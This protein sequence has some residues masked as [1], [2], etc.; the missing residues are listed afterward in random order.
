[1]NLADMTGYAGLAGALI[2]GIA[3]IPQ[4][5]HLIHEKC[6]AGLSVR[7]FSL[8]L[9]ATLLITAHAIAIMD[10]VFIVL[11]LVQTAAIATILFY[12]KLYDGQVCPSHVTVA[13]VTKRSK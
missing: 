7:A 3:Y 10:P 1:M 12:C 13:Q 6:S 8:W 11:G 4:I 5:T 2:A 9:L